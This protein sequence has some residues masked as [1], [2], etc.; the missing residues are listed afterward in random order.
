MTDNFKNNLGVI[1]QAIDMGLKKGV[2]GLQDA[3]TVLNAI[4]SLTA[5]ANRVSD[6]V[7]KLKKEGS[8]SEVAK[9]PPPTRELPKEV[10]K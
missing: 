5:E 4:T 9:T 1:E 2:Y 10:N 7:E 8:P 6:E 3:A